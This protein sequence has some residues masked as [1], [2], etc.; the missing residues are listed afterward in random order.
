[1]K[2][3]LFYLI[4]IL[5]WI[6]QLPQHLVALVILSLNK[7]VLYSKTIDGIKVYFVKRG[8]FKCGVSLGNF[9]ILD[10]AYDTISEKNLIMTAH[11]EYGHSKQSLMFGWLYLLVI[12]L[13]SVCNNIYSRIY[14]KDAKWYYN[15]YPENWAD[16][17]G[18]VH[19][20]D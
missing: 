13:P 14:K 1:M 18:N 19:R 7:G 11:H 20:W 17:L 2:K 6:W 5:S 12:G 4:S 8:V 16:K 15:R 10:Q 3:F 9:I